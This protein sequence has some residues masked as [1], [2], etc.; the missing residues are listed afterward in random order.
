MSTTQWI[1]TIIEV[2][3]GVALIIGFFYEPI[4]AEWEE[5]QKE[6]ILRAFKKRK[7]YRK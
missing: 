4:V 1:Q 2:I 5:K 3:V 6:K 7:E